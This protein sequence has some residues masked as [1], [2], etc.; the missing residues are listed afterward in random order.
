MGPDAGGNG[1]IDLVRRFNVMFS[2]LRKPLAVAAAAAVTPLLP[3]GHVVY[4]GM[5]ALV[6]NTD[7]PLIADPEIEAMFIDDIVATARGGFQALVDDARLLGR[8]WGFRLAEVKPPVLWWHGGADPFVSVA[9]V[10]RAVDH[11][12]D[13]DL[14]RLTGSSQLAMFGEVEPA[15]TFLHERL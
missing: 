13:A 9:D 6:P 7:K 12:S 5:T 3:L 15:L 14:I 11:M 2:A 4:Q 10:Q 1:A 8:D